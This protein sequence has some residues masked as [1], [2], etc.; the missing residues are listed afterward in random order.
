MKN[1]Y[2]L[3]LF[4]MC[5]GM[6]FA[7][8]PFKKYGYTPKIG[9][10]SK[11]KYIEHFD[12]DS[13]VQIGTVLFNT[14]SKKIVGFIVESIKLSEANLQPT[15]SSRWMNPD[16][17]A[18]EMSSWSP[19]NFAF[20]NPIYYIDPDG[21]APYDWYIDRLT[22]KVLG[23]DGAATDNLRVIDKREFDYAQQE[24]G[25]TTSTEA[26]QELQNNSS[27]ITFNETQIQNEAQSVGDDSAS[28]GVENQAFITLNVNT[29]E[30]AAQR[31]PDGKEGETTISSKSDKNNTVAPRT[32]NGLMLLAQMH[33]HPKTSVKGMKNSSSTSN[34]DK[35]TAASLGI[36][37]F[38]IDAFDSSK[39]AGSQ[40]AIHRVTK[41]GTKLDF[42]G[43]TKGTN[44]TGM[45]FTKH[46]RSLLKTG[47]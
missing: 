4:L 43:K 10:L 26:T 47:R 13:I 18:E 9:T 8:N 32:G 17:L 11:G 42:A 31:S 3:L 36:T 15:I 7:Q 5:F 12:N 29:G 21:L 28:E 35:N 19:Y 20:N 34:K 44:S 30:V 6:V 16:P 37:V 2:L 27:L 40:R 23:Q 41:S 46:L 39:G 14:H 22:G 38:A 25:S 33:G 1:K 24:Y 45:N